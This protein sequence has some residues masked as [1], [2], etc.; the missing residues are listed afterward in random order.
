MT[1]IRTVVLLEWGRS[2][3]RAAGIAS[4]ALD[5]LLLMSY[6]SGGRYDKVKLLT[7]GPDE[8]M[9]EAE[10]IFFQALIQKRARGAPVAYLIHQCEF[11]GLTFRIEESVLIPRPDT[12]TMVEEALELMRREGLQTVLELCTGSGCVGVSLA[13]YGGARVVATDISPEALA[14]AARNAD[15]CLG[16]RSDNCPDGQIQ[17][18][19]S[20]LFEA[21]P[22]G[23]YD[24]IAA[25][26]PYVVA[27]E[28][29][30]LPVSV[31]DYEP[32]I[33]LNGGPD[34]LDFYRR[35]AAAAGAYL[36]DGGVML[37]E[38]G[39][40]QAGAVAKILRGQGFADVTV[41]KDLAGLDR[42]VR[43]RY[44]RSFY[45]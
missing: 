4:A 33:A 32:R 25:N 1:A 45:V 44:N 38:I 35:I 28:I 31:R 39:Y 2:L 22:Q 8:R 43:C 6:A 13:H 15:D 9:T 34:G 30:S 5:V 42:L 36:T 26:P 18:V 40:D 23:P 3:L 11:M 24:M 41:K 10:T 20:D 27:S 19:L 16:N 17:F 7:A 14:L 29:A 37:L 21:V 12:E